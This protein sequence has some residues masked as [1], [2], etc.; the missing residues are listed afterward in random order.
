MTTTGCTY[1][2]AGCLVCPEIPAAT[3]HP[4]RMEVDPLLGW[5]AGANSSDTLDG[6]LGMSASIDELPIGV[7]L[8][9]KAGRAGETAPELIEHGLYI[10]AVGGQA[11]IEVRERGARQGE[12][13]AYTLG[14]TFEVRRQAG[15]VSYWLDGVHLRDSSRPSHGPV[16]VNACLYSAGDTIP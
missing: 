9:L 2:A 7:M 15:A 6:D 12:A 5:N 13:A 8:G 1:D 14:T 11:F 3:G 10:Y 4:A 16:L